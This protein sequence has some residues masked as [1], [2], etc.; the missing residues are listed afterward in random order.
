MKRCP[1]CGRDYLDDTLNFCLDDG[2]RLLYGPSAP[3][4]ET[5]LLSSETMQEAETRKLS[6]STIPGRYRVRTSK[7]GKVI[8]FAISLSALLGLSLWYLRIG[9]EDNATA[10][11]DQ[12]V[13]SNGIQKKLYWEMDDDHQARFVAEQAKRVQLLIGG[14]DDELDR[15]A[16]SAI[17]KEIGLFVE[18]RSSLSQKPFEEGLRSIFGRA[19]QFVPVVA[20]SFDAKRVPPAI[21]IY[22][23]MIESEYHDCPAPGDAI[24]EGKPPVGLF[25]FSRRTAANYGLKPEDYC[26]VPKQSDAAARYMSDLVSDFGPDGAAWTLAL[27]SFY[28][29][30]DAVREQLRE[31]RA[32][33]ETKRSFWA[34]YRYRGELHEELDEGS[35]RYVPRFFAAAI[36]GETPAVFDLPTPPLST[37]R[38]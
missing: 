1:E 23:A 16:I 8:L 2:V 28:Q 37:I 27:L 34:I 14:G 38:R 18:R 9:R 3:E 36:I 35:S 13:R 31:L 17:Q 15:E 21:G 5:I 7:G 12:N 33:G 11:E 26:N 19:T 30:E 10:K 22:Q 29:G 24:V 32:R 4:A 20:A 6:A 25:Q